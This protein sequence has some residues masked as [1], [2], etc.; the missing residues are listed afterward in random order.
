MA[1]LMW[2]SRL[3]IIIIIFAGGVY[4]IMKPNTIAA[5]N[6]TLAREMSKLIV[7]ADLKVQRKRLENQTRCEKETDHVK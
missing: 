2:I 3:N 7:E 6:E 1:G 4:D 5:S